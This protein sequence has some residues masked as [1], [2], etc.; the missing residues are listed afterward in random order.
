[1]K[2]NEKENVIIQASGYKD[3]KLTRICPKCKEEKP[4]EDFGLRKMDK[5]KGPVRNQSRCKKCR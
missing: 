5:E 3:G 4:L 1:M 2:N